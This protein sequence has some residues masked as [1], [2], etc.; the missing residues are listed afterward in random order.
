M[1]EKKI[2]IISD[3]TGQS[4]LH[5]VRAA[6]VQFQRARRQERRPRR[7]GH[8]ERLDE[9]GGDHHRAIDGVDQLELVAAQVGHR[10]VG[11]DVGGAG[12]GAPGRRGP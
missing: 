5:I 10:Q 12:A 9:R 8:G 11:P 7:V 2:F 4:G 1:S 3:A 6:I